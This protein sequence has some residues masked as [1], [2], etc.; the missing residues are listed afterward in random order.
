[1]ADALS[2]EMGLNH[3]AQ[4]QG[5]I[6]DIHAEGDSHGYSEKQSD[7]IFDKELHSSEK[8][9]ERPR[10]SSDS[11]RLNRQSSGVN[12]EQAEKD[13]AELSRELSA[14]SRRISRT[15]SKHSAARTRDIEKAVSSS[16]ENSEDAFDLETTLRGAREADDAAGIKSKYIGE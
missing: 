14:I 8:N 9:R 10:I 5:S 6:V 12:V 2:K 15:Q 11:Y 13:F 7:A 16:D 4:P 1:M 3:S